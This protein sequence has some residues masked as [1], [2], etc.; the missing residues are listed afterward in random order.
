MITRELWQRIMERDRWTCQYCGRRSDQLDHVVPKN[1]RRRMGIAH[2]DERYLVAA[3]STCNYRKSIFRLL[4][5]R[6]EYL[7]AELEERSGK[8]WRV[9]GGEP[10]S[11]VL[12]VR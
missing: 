5:P 11:E 2:D 10:L 8:T 6:L 12:E 4:P 9:W 3:C 1:E 7:K